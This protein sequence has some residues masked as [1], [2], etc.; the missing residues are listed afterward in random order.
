MNLSFIAP[1]AIE[2]TGHSCS[3]YSVVLHSKGVLGNYLNTCN[4]GSKTTKIT[5]LVCHLSLD[6]MFQQES[7]IYSPE[8]MSIKA[9][10][11]QL[12]TIQ[13]LH[14]RCQYHVRAVSNLT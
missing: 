8:Q 13:C 11:P 12:L 2:P 10:E 7:N 3:Q 14:A 4:E 5:Q 1:K 6:T 9:I